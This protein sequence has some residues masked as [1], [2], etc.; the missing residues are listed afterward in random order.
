M[1]LTQNPTLLSTLSGLM[2]L[3]SGWFYS[4]T[5]V[6]VTFTVNYSEDFADPNLND[7]L[8]DFNLT[9]PELDCSLRTAID[10]INQLVFNGNT[11]PHTVNVEPAT[12]PGNTHQISF[13]SIDLTGNIRI[14][15]I[16]PVPPIIEVLFINGNSYNAILV[17]QN[18]AQV[19]IANLEFRL[20]NSTAAGITASSSAT[21]MMIEDTIFVPG[22]RFDEVG[23]NM[24]DGQVTCIRCLLRNG[25]NTAVQVTGGQLRMIDSEVRNNVLNDNDSLIN[26]AGF[27]ISG[28]QTWLLRTQ[29]SRNESVN[30]G[31]GIYLNGGLLNLVNT[32]ISNNHADRSGAGILISNGQVIIENT[33]ITKNVANADNAGG[34]E[35]GGILTQSGG[36][37]VMKNSIL[38]GNT[39]TGV[40]STNECSGANLETNG[41]NII[42]TDPD[43][44]PV[45]VTGPP[46]IRATV[47]L[48]I[49]IRDDYWGSL[50]TDQVT[51]ALHPAVDAGDASQCSADHDLDPA[52]AQI[53][54]VN[55]IRIGD[56]PLDGN[57]DAVVDCD[58]GAFE[59][60]CAIDGTDDDIDGVGSLCDNCPSDANPS[61]MDTD[62]DGIGDACDTRYVLNVS[63]SG[64]GTVTSS[65]TGIN[66]G[67]TC[68]ADFL[69]QTLVTLTP[70]AA[71]GFA[72]VTWG[73]DCSGNG[74]CQVNMDQARNISA[75]FEVSGFNLQVVLSGNGSGAVSSAPAGINC[76]SDCNELYTDTEAVTLTPD[77]DPGF[78]FLNWAGD[79]SGNTCQVT[80]D[81]ERR[82][83]AVFADSDTIFIDGAE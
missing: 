61:Q 16:G 71:T 14:Q 29:V 31:G 4:P 73:G 77:P 6:S 38:S 78:Q 10:Q 28:G 47:P 56:R 46:A 82:V 23:L 57:F 1:K 45:L 25:N 27:N 74:S 36:V 5:A 19:E 64:D 83:L 8:C 13:G 58:L 33:T 60:N 55:D 24:E 30:N 79:C 75:L 32:T 68:S 63:T 66:C 40:T 42:G 70:S 7:G 54:L 12:F 44:N 34:G 20:Q 67:S 59:L 51:S 39:V 72:F 9:T 69:E 65:P 43:C 50:T 76:P 2:W 35:G 26:G 62:G 17:S 49:L 21:V 48:S 41:P 53:P 3:L 37:A 80:M 11:G 22:S 81:N 18:D 52:T 15:G